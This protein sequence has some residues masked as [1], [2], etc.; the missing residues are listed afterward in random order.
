[1]ASWIADVESKIYTMVKYKGEQALKGKYPNIYYTTDSQA[2][3]Q[4]SFPTVFV[5][6]MS[7]DE[8]GQ[9]LE[10]KTINAFLCSLQIDVTVSKSQGQT[11]AREVVWQSI[12]T[13]K[14]YY[15][16]DIFDLPKFV[17][18]GNE[19][20]RIVARARRIVGASETF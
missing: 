7:N 13:L 2:T 12:E 1:M 5:N 6:F 17:E 8:R 15:S 3:T 14:K 16:F 10:G 18:T 9:D 19:T 11:V 4:T 20:V